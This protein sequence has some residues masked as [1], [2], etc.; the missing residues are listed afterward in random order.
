MQ[1]KTQLDIKL[2]QTDINEA[3][4]AFLATHGYTVHPEDVENIKYVNTRNDGMTASITVSNESDTSVAEE[5]LLGEST[6]P[7]TTAEPDPEPVTETSPV[8]EEELP[9]G[10]IESN[11][12]EDVMPAVDEIKEMVAEPTAT[13]TPQSSLF[14]NRY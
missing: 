7:Q 6:E 11:T 4:V 13:T 5:P 1:V 9:P 3:V 2:N 14:K 8:V 10:E 12:V